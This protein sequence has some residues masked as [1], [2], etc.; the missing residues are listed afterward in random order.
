MGEDYSCERLLG[1][2]SYGKVALATKK[3]TGRK[4]AIKRMENI[5]EDETDCKRILREV[6][7]MRKLRHPFVVE[8]VELLFP[9]NPQTFDTLYVVM[10]Y[11]ESD[12][13]KII[14]SNINLEMQHTQHII[15]NLLCAVKYLHE[16]NVLHR[17]LKPANVLINEDCTVKLCD[18][19]LARSTSGIESAAMILSAADKDSDGADETVAAIVEQPE[20]I[21]SA[22]ASEAVSTKGIT[23]QA[24]GEAAVT[25]QTDEEKKEN[26]RSRLV[27]T[28]EARR[29]MTRKLTG[30]VVTRWY[31]APEIIL[32]E[33]DYGP[34]IDIWAVGCIFAELLGMMR[35]NAATFM[36][37]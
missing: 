25:E 2:G 15:Y 22:A 6:T 11:A 14:K 17:D 33:K 8:L 23:A 18:Y 5:F 27:K 29:G 1:T 10:E 16:S 12:L 4:V 3:S 9:S 28:K 20:P 24:S 30:H 26:L 7:L 37:R 34:G 32:L 31:R 35:E 21:K 36:D 19:G 13:K